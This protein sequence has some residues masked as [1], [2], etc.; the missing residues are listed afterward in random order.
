VPGLSK[1]PVIGRLFSSRSQVKDQDVLLVLV[2]PTIIL[3]QEKE[4]EYFA[5]LE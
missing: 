2:K 1:I 3:Q 5:P 4:R